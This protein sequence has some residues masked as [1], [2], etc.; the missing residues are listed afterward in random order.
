MNLFLT[1]G[2]NTMQSIYRYIAAVGIFCLL[3]GNAL[4][5]RAQTV[6]FV[7]K[8]EREVEVLEKGVKVKKTVPVQKMVPGDEVVYTV[9]F[10]NK[11]GK[12][13]DN[14]VVT[15]P[16]PKFTRYKDGSAAG[17][18]SDISYSVDGGKTFATPDKLTVAGKDKSGKDS[19]RAAGGADYTHIRWVVKQVVAPG[20]SGS[21]RFRAI[22]L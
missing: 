21:V 13:V 9:T 5:V 2:G 6:E 17:D 10:A 16:V 19:V 15:N 3:A 18:N 7:T 14:M 8:A 4:V 1:N 20:Q 11:T 12:P 22:I